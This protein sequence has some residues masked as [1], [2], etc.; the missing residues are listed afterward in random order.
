MKGVAHFISTSG[1]YG[2]ER[3][4]LALLNHLDK[5]NTLLIC[6]STAN[7]DLLKEAKKLGI[8]TKLLKVKANFATRDFVKN[9]S[10]LLKKEK[11]EIIHTHGYK[12]DILG[13]FAAKIAGIKII[14]TPH[15]WSKNGG[16]KLRVY[17]LI[18]KIIL[19]HF[20]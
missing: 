15:G 12:A 18:D 16:L 1:V 14:S 9:L 10:E 11:I 19:K 5:K 7:T 20:D 8:R 6:P 13:Y 3:W 4:I 2:A 17:E